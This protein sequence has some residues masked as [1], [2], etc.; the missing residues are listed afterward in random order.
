[1]RTFPLRPDKATPDRLVSTLTLYTGVLVTGYLMPPPP[2][3]THTFLCFF[4]PLGG[5]EWPPAQGRR[6]GRWQRAPRRCSVCRI[7]IHQ[8]CLTA[9]WAMSSTV[10]RRQHAFLKGAFKQKHLY[11]EVIH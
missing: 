5:V 2:T 10:T 3:H 8:A 1:M 6:A 11:N 4:W 9:L 7:S